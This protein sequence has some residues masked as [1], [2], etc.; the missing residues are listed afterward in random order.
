MPSPIGH[1]LAGLAVAWGSDL[2]PGA[3]SWRA[4][5]ASARWRERAGGTLT[6]TCAALA[7]A[8]DLDLL[9][10]AHRM[11][12]HSIAAVVL[13]GLVAG[14]WAAGSGRPVLR[15]AL[16]CGGAWATHLVLDWLAVDASPPRGIQLLWPFSHAWLVSGWDLFASTQRRNPLSDRA[17]R[18]NAWAGAREIAIL[19]PIV[20]GLWL[21]RVKALARFST[22]LTRSDHPAE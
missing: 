6:W 19:V 8:P 9:V 15:I 17:M 13:V 3:R 4:A 12:T 2:V 10:G 20:F 11:G 1:A 21:V 22:E 16:M 7:A 5:P 14:A 18:E